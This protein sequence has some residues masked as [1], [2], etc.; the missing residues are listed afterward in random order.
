MIGTETI[1]KEIFEVFLRLIT[2]K[3]Q[4]YGYEHLKHGI[5]NMAE[6]QKKIKFP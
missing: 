5:Q 1:D 2:A 4:L 3:W 6:A